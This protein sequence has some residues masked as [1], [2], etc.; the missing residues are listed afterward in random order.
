VILASIWRN[1]ADYIDRYAAQ[2]KALREHTPVTVIAV[3]GDS[4]DDTYEMLKGGPDILLK[5]EHG[6]PLFPSTVH[7]L[8]WRQ[9]A[10]AGNVALC[11]AYRLI[12]SDP[13]PLCYVESDLI[14]DAETMMVLADDLARVPAVA[15]MSM[16]GG[17]FYDIWGHSKNGKRFSAHPPYCDDYDPD[18]LFPIDTAGSCFMVR[19]ELVEHL[20]FSHIDCIHGIGRSIREASRTLYLDPTVAVYHP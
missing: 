2:V 17:R 16:Q 15:P 20:Q 8:R 4:T 14:W 9:L 10:A 11:A 1:S 3:E 5:A 18:N 6:G 13:Q 12:H 7:P 19:A